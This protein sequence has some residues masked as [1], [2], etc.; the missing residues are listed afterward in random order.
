[1]KTISKILASSNTER[2]LLNKWCN[3]CA[4]DGGYFSIENKVEDKQLFII[5][6]I[7]WPEPVQSAERKV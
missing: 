3:E 7:D 6:T 1:M 5:Y 4:E 2:A